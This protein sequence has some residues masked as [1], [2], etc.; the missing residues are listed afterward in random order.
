MVLELW[1]SFAVT[2]GI[3]IAIPGPTNLMVMA[4]GFRYGTRSALFTVLGVAPGAAVAM[5]L[6]FLGLGGV[7]AV[8]SHLF[9][10]MK[11]IGAIYLVY[12][13]ILLWRSTPKVDTV[14]LDEKCVPGNKIALQAFTISLL[15]PKHII[16]YMAFIPQFVSP[17]APVF[18]QLLIL[19]FTFIMLVFPI[20]LAYALMSGRLRAMIKKQSLLRA[21]N[22]SGGALLIGAGVFTASLRRT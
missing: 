17:T 3:F 13:G 1:L 18:R 4:Y 7:L 16:F 6:S 5:V 20:N 19:G 10:A 8:S 14:S 12:Q 2:S 21:M 15:N 9:V 22:R 11:W